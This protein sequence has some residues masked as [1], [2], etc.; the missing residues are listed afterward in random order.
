[1][2]ANALEV[3]GLGV[4]FGRVVGLDNVRFAV[5]QGGTLAVIG[6]NGSGK[7]VLF[8]VLIGA[9]HQGSRS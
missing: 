4:R 6:P 7:T 9:V 1:M 3:E 8:Q 2:T 5:P